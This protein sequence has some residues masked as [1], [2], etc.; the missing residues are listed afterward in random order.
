MD[1]PTARFTTVELDYLLGER[2]LG[3]LATI[4]ENGRPHVVP[5]GWSYNPGLGT[6]DLSGHGFAGTRKFRNV[7]ANP[8]AAFVVDDVLPRWQP[9]CVMVQGRAAQALDGSV[10]GSAEAMIRITPEKIISWGLE[11]DQPTGPE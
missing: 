3:R 1:R 9:R 8:T 10:A 5:L 2:R 11:A 6:I 4:D 7:Q